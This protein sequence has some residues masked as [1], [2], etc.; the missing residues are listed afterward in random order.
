MS[1]LRMLAASPRPLADV[2]IDALRTSSRLS[3]LLPILPDEDN[4]GP[5]QF[6]LQLDDTSVEEYASNTIRVCIRTTPQ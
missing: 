6:S 2:L 3:R 1:R 4:D 5:D